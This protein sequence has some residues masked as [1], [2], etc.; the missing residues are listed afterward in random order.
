MR[1]LNKLVV[2]IAALC[3][4]TAA[5][6][7]MKWD[8]P[9]EQS[10]SSLTGIADLAFADGVREKT[11]GE[12]DIT[13]HFGGALGFKTKD[14]YDA[15]ATGAV[16]LADSYTG[17]LVG[18]DSVW[19]VSALP[20]LTGGID[21]AWKLYQASKPIYS[22]V[23]A[24]QNQIL[25]YTIPWT[26]SGI[27]AN[28]PIESLE[29]LSDLKMRVYDPL[30]QMTFEAAGATPITL[31]FSDVVPQL[32]T[33]GIEAVLTSAEGGYQ[34][35]FA[36]LL[37]N[38]T[39]ISYAS[40]LSIV[41]MNADTWNGLSDEQRTA[42]SEAAAE[43]EAMIWERASSREA[44]VFDKMREAGIDISNEVSASL[45]ENLR[46]AADAAV[47]EWLAKSGDR[48]AAILEAY[49]GG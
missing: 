6:A 36:D 24:D 18:F 22:E 25:L 19:Q 9:T 7:D 41:H 1:L 15:V 37:S 30:G 38:F 17:P 34:N 39:A 48:G 16:V 32:T 8:L 42:V 35:K 40:P 31:S 12:I 3:M 2:S 5:S 29:D 4:A 14:H 43:A 20:F 23:L 21:D 11:G 44:D 49:R 26:P 13:V 10:E 45:A 47:Q 27:W 28:K 33:G 46:Q